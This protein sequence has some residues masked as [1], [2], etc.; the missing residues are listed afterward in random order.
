MLSRIE[1]NT[2]KNFDWDWK[3]I[4]FLQRYFQ[5]FKLYLFLQSESQNLKLNI[6]LWTYSKQ[7][8]SPTTSWRVFLLLK[9]DRSPR[10]TITQDWSATTRVWIFLVVQFCAFLVLS[11]NKVGFWTKWY[12]IEDEQLF[13]FLYFW[14]GYKTS[15]ELQML[16]R[17]ISDCTHYSSMS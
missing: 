7:P 6:K 4:Q 5:R 17:S 13:Y 1:W 15:Q 3:K 8:W 12:H 10:I 11:Q 16:S 9:S 2:P 14:Y